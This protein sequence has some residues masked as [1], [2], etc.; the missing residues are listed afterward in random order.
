MSYINQRRHGLYF[1][2]IKRLQHTHPHGEKPVL[3]R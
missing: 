3:V 1:P 2:K